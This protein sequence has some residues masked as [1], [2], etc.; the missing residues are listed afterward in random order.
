M[1]LYREEESD[2]PRDDHPG[3][4]LHIGS[5]PRHLRKPTDR[6][7]GN[8]FT[9]IFYRSHIGTMPPTEAVRIGRDGL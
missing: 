1:A 3:L 4:A 7:T 9:F 5:K 6:L 8:S 2:M